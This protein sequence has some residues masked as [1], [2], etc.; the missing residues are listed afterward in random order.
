MKL[1]QNFMLFLIVF[2]LCLNLFITFYQKNDLVYSSILSKKKRTHKSSSHSSSKTEQT[3]A[4]LSATNYASGGIFRALPPPILDRYII[5]SAVYYG[6]ISN[7]KI[8]ISEVIG[9]A[10]AL[11][12]TAVIPKLEECHNIFDGID[13]AHI[14]QLFD[15]SLFSRASVISRAGFDASRIC[16]DDVISIPISGFHGFDEV[17]S[18]IGSDNKKMKLDQI[19]LSKPFFF[20]S[21]NDESLETILNK[22]PYKSHFNPET[23]VIASRYMTD[24]L[25]PDKLATLSNYKCIIIGRNFYSLNWNRLPREFQEIHKE[26]QP[27]PTIRADALE[28]LLQNELIDST[29]SPTKPTILPFIA[30]HLRMGDFVSKDAHHSFGVICNRDPDILSIKVKEALKSIENRQSVDS[31]ASATTTTTISSRLPI[32]LATDDY[33]SSCANHLRKTFPTLIQLDG[34][35]R[36]HVRSCR[37]ALFDQEILGASEYFFGDQ[38]ST[39]SQAIHQIRTLRHMKD[40]ESTS[41]L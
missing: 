21:T 4:W 18:D 16:G 17:K 24:L 37:G 33:S 2:L 10:L 29:S 41:W 12:R 26:M 30:I 35:S 1:P 11:N 7:A 36:F 32:I 22:F 23:K 9:L 39:F 14:D 13:D 19:L 38:K 27:N 31:S 6:R 8:S 15:L 25:V 20:G 40:V 3:G 28:F 5:S 34:A